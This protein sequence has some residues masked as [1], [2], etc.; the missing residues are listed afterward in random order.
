MEQPVAAT[1][2]VTS[3]KKR[4]GKAYSGHA[5]LRFL[6]RST[7]IPVDNFYF[8]LIKSRQAVGIHTEPSDDELLEHIGKGNSLAK[9]EHVLSVK[10]DQS[11]IIHSDKRA[12]YR[13]IGSR[14]VAVMNRSD[15]SAVTILTAE[16]AKTSVPE[17]ALKRHGV[18]KETPHPTLTSSEIA[19]TSR[20]LFKIERR[21][22][23]RARPS[24]LL[25][26]VHS[27]EPEMEILSG[28]GTLCLVVVAHSRISLKR[29]GEFGGLTVTPY[30]P[31]DRERRLLIN[32]ERDRFPDED[33]DEIA[34]KSGYTIRPPRKVSTAKRWFG[35]ARSRIRA[36]GGFLRRMASFLV[37]GR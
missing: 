16:Q 12:T 37:S 23:D 31:T 28:R 4:K 8:S 24:R 5:L 18:L 2:F 10:L 27:V 17:K 30:F 3:K 32:A 20:C 21:R 9:F 26:A 29:F 25:Q 35:I 33:W 1:E 19:A 22:A 11:R 36:A 34:R 15:S 14:L 6:E 13:A 7:R